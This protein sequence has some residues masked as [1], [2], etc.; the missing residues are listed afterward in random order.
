MGLSSMIFPTK[1]QVFMVLLSKGWFSK[2]LLSKR[3]AF[4]RD[5]F[6]SYVRVCFLKVFSQEAIFSKGFVLEKG[7]LQ[8]VCNLRGMFF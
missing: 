5:M 8:R 3:P 6:S 4:L 7:S 2:G 1:K